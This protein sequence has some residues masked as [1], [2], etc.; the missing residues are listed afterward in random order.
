M[1][2]SVKGSLQVD[3]DDVEMTGVGKLLIFLND[4]A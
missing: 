2:H 3:K 1:I 4:E